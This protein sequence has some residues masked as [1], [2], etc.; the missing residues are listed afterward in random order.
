MGTALALALGPE[1]FPVTASAIKPEGALLGWSLL[2]APALA[3]LA[4]FIPALLAASLDPAV[5]LR[6]E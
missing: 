1:I 3:A 6:E 4:S 2:L 5:A